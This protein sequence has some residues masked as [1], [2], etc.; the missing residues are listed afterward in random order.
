MDMEFELAG[1]ISSAD[2]PTIHAALNDLP[3]VETVDFLEGGGIAVRY[4]PEKVTREGI[5]TVV[6]QNGFQVR[7]TESAPA[8][9][10]IEAPETGN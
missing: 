1:P 5:L 8:A 6:G 10:V 4:D 9:P 3:G 2:H 7:G